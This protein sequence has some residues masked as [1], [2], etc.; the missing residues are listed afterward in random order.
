MDSSRPVA[1]AAL[2]IAD[3]PALILSAYFNGILVEFH[4]PACVFA[5]RSISSAAKFCAA[6]TLVECPLTSA[7]N[8][9]PRADTE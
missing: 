8:R 3:L 5:A 2:A 9:S 7:T 6:P 4:P 1:A